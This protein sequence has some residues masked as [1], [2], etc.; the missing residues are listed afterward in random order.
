[1]SEI[2]TTDWDETAASNNQTAPNGMPE[3][4]A[5]SG[6][7]DWG[8]ET[9]AAIKRWF[10]RVTGRTDAGALVASAGTS[11]VIT[12][13]YDTAP[14]S[15]YT[16]LECA[17]K[18]TTTCGADPTLNVNSLGAKNI[19]KFDGAYTNLAAGEIAANQH[20]RVK[21]DG[22][23]D[24]WVL[25]SPRPAYLR[26]HIAGLTLSNGTDATNDIDIAVGETT[27]SDRS[28]LIT[29]SSALTKQLDAA[30]AVGTN[31]GMRATGVAI[32][33][34]TY[35]IFLIRRPDTGVVDV[36]ADT[37]VSGANIAANT[38]A[39]YTQL[40]RI[41]SITRVS[42]AIVAFKQHGDLFVR[43]VAAGN[44][45]TANPGTSAVTATLSV[46]TGLVVNARVSVGLFDSTIASSTYFLAT[47]LSQ[48]DSTP[49]ANL[50]NLSLDVGT[51]GQVWTALEVPTNT[52][53]QIRYR[54]SASTADH[55]V[56]I[57]T[58]GWVDRRGR[59]D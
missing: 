17:F 44:V 7:N 22:T 16:G 19:Q 23:L 31:A 48:T 18:V 32:A 55:T 1:M 9:M 51:V 58:T 30:W 52:S 12:V 10:N 47:A 56:R 4:M 25:T 59:D 13:A 6:V 26:G 33:D 36:A 57:V 11:T 24:K 8:R 3:G 28:G 5:P 29:L 37:S 14:A 42:N 46:P 35:H 54:L 38:D 20:V 53:A 45:N 41:G 39:A 21:Y 50:S 40:R 49:A 34:G 43:D 15:L 27:T 2:Q